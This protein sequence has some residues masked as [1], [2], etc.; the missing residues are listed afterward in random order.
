MGSK[1]QRTSFEKSAISHET[2][3]GEKGRNQS[4][5]LSQQIMILS[6]ILDEF[7]KHIKN[8]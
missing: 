5:E 8:Y 2:G 7:I 1:Y 4:F 6:I 3:N